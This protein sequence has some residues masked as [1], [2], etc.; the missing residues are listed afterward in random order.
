MVNGRLFHPLSVF[1]LGL[2]VVCLLGHYLV[3]AISLGRQANRSGSK[4]PLLASRPLRTARES[5]PFKPL[6]PLKR[7][8]PDAV[9]QRVSLCYEPVG[10]S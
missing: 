9:S 5:F 1:W 7:P 3:D 8:L 4:R 2:A 6:K 10:D